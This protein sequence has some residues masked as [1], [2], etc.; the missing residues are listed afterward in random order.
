MRS[1]RPRDCCTICLRNV[2]GLFWQGRFGTRFQNWISF[3]LLSSSSASGFSIFPLVLENDDDDE[4]ND[5]DETKTNV[6]GSLTMVC[7]QAQQHSSLSEG[8]FLVPFSRTDTCWSLV[9][10]FWRQCFGISF[11][12]MPVFRSLLS[13]ARRY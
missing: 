9:M 13:K 8:K 5:N 6:V 7:A 3:I 10:E 2:V 12:L 11:L 4:D 1:I